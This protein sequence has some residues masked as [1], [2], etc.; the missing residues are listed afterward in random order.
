MMKSHRIGLYAS[1]LSLF[2]ALV[3][4]LSYLNTHKPAHLVLAVICVITS[5]TMYLRFRRI[6]KLS[7]TDAAPATNA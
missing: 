2:M 4:K 7:H 6:R 1:A 3:F 5:V